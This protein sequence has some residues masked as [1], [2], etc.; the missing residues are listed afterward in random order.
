VIIGDG[1]VRVNG[2]VVTTPAKIIDTSRDMVELDG[3]PV[4]PDTTRRYY[5]LN[6]P[7]GV[8][9]TLSDPRGRPT[10]TDYCPP[11]GV[12]LYPAGRLDADTT[13]LVLLTDDGKLAYRVMH[14]SFSL[15]KKY[16]ALVTGEIG[17]RA[18]RRLVD[19]IDLDDRPAH[20]LSVSCVAS[21][22]HESVVRLSLGEGRKRQI[23]RMCQAVGH[24]VRELHREAIG[25]LGLGDLDIGN[26][27]ELSTFE[28]R[29]LRRAIGLGDF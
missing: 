9:S 11:G 12:R 15:E 8:L 20:A 1:R 5:V 23:R 10:L 19:G 26:T 17:S 27:R 16:L 7:T 21:D 22:G 14:P 18:M 25:P 13:G 3:R 28:V 6:K 2:E 29:K 4:A 24:P